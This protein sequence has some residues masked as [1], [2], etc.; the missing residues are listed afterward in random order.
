M[1]LTV[2]FGL[3][4]VLAGLIL[5]PAAHATL[6]YDSGV[7]YASTTGGFTLFDNTT[8]GSMTGEGFHD[9]QAWDVQT[10]VIVADFTTDCVA[11]S[12]NLQIVSAPSLTT[13]QSLSSLPITIGPVIATR[14][15]LYESRQVTIDVGSLIVPAGDHY[16]GLGFNATGTFAGWAGYNQL[17]NPADLGGIY[18]T[19]GGTSWIGNYPEAHAMFSIY[20][21]FA[22]V[23]EP[24]T[25]ALIVIGGI[26]AL[27]RPVRKE[28]KD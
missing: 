23:P 17:I 12:A 4:Q 16:L 21:E 8:P 22:N 19:N 14:S 26:A 1:R 3:A 13:Q 20:G 11:T 24:G 7:P 28:E 27:R 25:L 10:I 5:V 6:L 9:A 15:G 2:S 18:T